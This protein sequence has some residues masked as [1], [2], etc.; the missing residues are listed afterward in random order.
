MA[1]VIFF[2]EFE[3]GGFLGGL[4]D[5]AEGL[6]EAGHHLEDWLLVGVFALVFSEFWVKVWGTFWMGFSVFFDG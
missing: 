2:I 3:V 1:A 4:L 6:G 5:H